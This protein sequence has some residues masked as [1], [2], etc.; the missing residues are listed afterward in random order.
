M[1]VSIL[2][3]ITNAATT[4]CFRGFVAMLVMDNEADGLSFYPSGL[5]I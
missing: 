5:R 1:Q 2:F 3:S 4:I